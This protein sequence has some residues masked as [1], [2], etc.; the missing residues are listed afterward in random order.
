[1]STGVASAAPVYLVS[2]RQETT[3]RHI[4]G[5]GLALVALF[6]YKA[7]GAG[8]AS[9]GG[10]ALGSS[11]F[12]AVFILVAKTPWAARTLTKYPVLTDLV[13]TASAF[14]VFNVAFKGVTATPA[15]IVFGLLVSAS[16]SLG[17]LYMKRR[18]I[19]LTTT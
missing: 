12:M 4:I 18:K 8:V 16:T 5:A 19:S 9:N 17:A 2:L 15:A 6:I 3:M 14:F 11:T 7:T 1:M 13:L 10:W